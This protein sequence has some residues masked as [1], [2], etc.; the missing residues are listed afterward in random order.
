MLAAERRTMA[1]G[2]SRRRAVA[3]N[4]V[5]KARLAAEL[6]GR[7]LG[8][9]PSLANFLCVDLAREAAPVFRG[10]LERGV[11]VLPRGWWFISTEHSAAD[12]EATLE[13]ARDV[14][15]ELGASPA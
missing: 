1:V 8:S 4:R 15:S 5:E 10:L 9:L 2:Q 3:S 12:V 6:R 11:I 14:F 7:G 13:A